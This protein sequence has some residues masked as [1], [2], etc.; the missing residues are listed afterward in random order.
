MGNLMPKTR[1]FLSMTQTV[2]I[3]FNGQQCDC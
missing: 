3:T 1:F 2:V